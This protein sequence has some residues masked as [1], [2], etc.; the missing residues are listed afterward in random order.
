M[1]GDIYPEE[2]EQ[3]QQQFVSGRKFKK[4]KERTKKF[5]ETTMDDSKLKE[6][7]E[8]VGFFKF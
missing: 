1:R 2:E 4:R 6:Q 8:T 3:I 7:Q 5:K